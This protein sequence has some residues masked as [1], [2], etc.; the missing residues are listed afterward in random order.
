MAQQPLGALTPLLSVAVTLSPAQIAALHTTPVVLIPA[1]GAGKIIFVLS[2]GVFYTWGGV[3]Y[4]AAADAFAVQYVGSGNSVLNLGNF[5][6]VLSVAQSQYAYQP[7]GPDSAFLML[8]GDDNQPVEMQASDDYPA[9][10][11]GASTIGAHGTGYVLNDTGTIT[12]GQGDATYLIT[13]VGA[14][15]IVTSFK[16]TYAGT[17]YTVGAGQATATGGSQPGVGINFTINVN[18]LLAGNG[19]LK[20]VVYY[21]II[22]VT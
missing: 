4:Y 13:G 5:S 14:L 7:G 19:T 20:V 2:A 16:I 15:G 17:G 12:T 11:V 10:G 8:S 3:S 1:P 21:Q 9:S 18:A 6:N 22:D